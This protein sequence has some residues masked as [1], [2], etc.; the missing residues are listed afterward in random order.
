M[1]DSYPKLDLYLFTP[2]GNLYKR[3]R[4]N[5]N[6]DFYQGRNILFKVGFTV[7]PI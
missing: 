6:D 2:Y 7:I 3:E 1:A 5:S 4:E